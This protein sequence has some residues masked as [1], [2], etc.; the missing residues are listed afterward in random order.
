MI[1]GLQMAVDQLPLTPLTESKLIPIK[2]MIHAYHQGFGNNLGTG[3]GYQ[4]NKALNLYVVDFFN[5]FLKNEKNPFLGCTAL[6]N[7][8]RMGCGP[9][10]F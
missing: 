7:N 9:G 3:N 6:T 2:K 5:V 10:I 1:P 4:I 8:T